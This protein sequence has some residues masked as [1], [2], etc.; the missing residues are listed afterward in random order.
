MARK[1][2]KGRFKRKRENYEED[3]EKKR[4]K[5]EGDYRTNKGWSVSP[6]ENDKF[7]EFYKAQ[8]IVPEE[9][10]DDFMKTLQTPLPTTFRI[11]TMNTFAPMLQER[12]KKDFIE[13]LQ[14]VDIDDCRNTSRKDR[15]KLVAEMQ[16]RAEGQ[17]GETSEESEESAQAPEESEEA[18]DA[19][20]AAEDAA[21]D[22]DAQ[23][24]EKYDPP[25]PLPWYPNEYGWHFT[26]SRALL[27]RDINLYAFHQ[28]LISQNQSGGLTRQ[29][30]VSMVPPLMLDVKPHHRVLD[31]CA[32]PGSKTSQILEYL[33]A[34][35]KKTGEIPTGIVV[36][37]DANEDRC[38]MLFHQIMKLGSTNCLV[39]N[40]DAQFFPS[41]RDPVTHEYF[42]FDRVLADVPCSGDGTMRK[43]AELWNRWKPM[44][45]VALHRLQ[46]D[47]AIRGVQALKVGGRMVYSTCS[48]NP[49]ED[50]S[51]VAQVLR[52]FNGNVQLVD[53]SDQL[54]ELQRRPGISTWKVQE[55]NGTW[56]DTY[57]E[58][59]R[60]VRHICKSMFPPTEE[61]NQWMHLERCIRLLPHLQNTGG[62]F[63][64]VLEKVRDKKR[65]LDGASSTSSADTEEPMEVEEAAETDADGDVDASTGSEPS[66]EEDAKSD[67]S[68]KDE[69]KKKK[70]NPRWAPDAPFIFLA[71]EES[72]KATLETIKDFY[73]ISDD[74]PISNLFVRAEGAPAKIYMMSDE[75]LKMFQMDRAEKKMRVVNTGLRIFQKERSSASS[76]Y[77]VTSEGV[78]VLANF[79]TKR[80]VHIPEEE[81]IL[82]IES[83]EVHF[84]KFSKDTVEA[85]EA[86]S[87][88]SFV[89]KVDLSRLGL[90]TAVFVGWRG[91]SPQIHLLVPKE[92][93]SSLHMLLCAPGT[94]YTAEGE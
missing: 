18:S 83:N 34:D 9:E 40:H 29:E 23:P 92:Q 88:G 5:Q 59:E 1:G 46:V 36:A 37:N 82:L 64:A 32:A 79:M 70:K 45:G 24:K 84:D 19:A 20:G 94:L 72:W 31:M 66:K 33:E 28:F 15:N 58:T 62:F 16:A 53:V 6:E 77:R 80:V 50:E 41:L 68:E 39:T 2:R 71:E 14:N 91:N 81:L 67:T 75:L 63:V 73:G 8:G 13:K 61:E 27:R 21:D 76:V 54:P 52:Y 42:L 35:W 69:K 38:Y 57:E 51:V 25:I 17:T 55:P 78:R 3:P 65:K 86:M 49:M 85:V 43:N 10:W 56:F 4:L 47:I 7:N 22:A 11:N 30:A 74:F 60:K 44:L 87:V 12:M 90:G 26:A 93:R 48:F 89:I